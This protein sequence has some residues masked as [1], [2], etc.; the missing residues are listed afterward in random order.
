MTA[1]A[2]CF[3]GFFRLGLG[4]L[5]VLF[6]SALPGRAQ[7]QQVS[8]S[9]AQGT[10]LFRR[11]LHDLD[12]R[13]LQTYGQLVNDESK[14]L[15]IVLGEPGYLHPRQ[16]ADFVKQGGAVLLATDRD[17]YNVLK[18]FGVEV[19]GRPV[20]VSADTR[21]AYKRSEECI[22]VQPHGRESHL[23]ENLSVEDGLSRVATN[24]PGYLVCTPGCQLELLATFPPGCRTMHARPAHRGPYSERQPGV[25]PDLLP[26]AV[27]GDWEQG[28]VLILCDHS[29]FINAMMW[30]PDID[31]LDFAYN[32]V[33]WLTDRGKRTQVLFLEEGQVQTSFEIP[34]KE[35]PLPPLKAIVE[36]VNKGLGELERDNAFNR[37]I[38]NAVKDASPPQDQWERAVILLSTLALAAFGLARLSQARHRPEKAAPLAVSG[39]GPTRPTPSLFEQ[40]HQSMV[41]EGNFWEAARALARQ[42][43]ESVLGA[44]F[45]ADRQPSVS[46]VLALLGVQGS[47]WGKWRLRR[48]FN[49]LWQLAYGVEPIRI[50]SRQLTRLGSEIELMK[51]ALAR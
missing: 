8:Q 14:K 43:F 13:P 45:Q 32:C 42:G 30:Q 7:G 21:F 10:H 28:R 1:R 35:P 17:C 27:G 11:I 22:F 31:N 41:Q 2:Y 20:T 34:L 5:A 48:R 38:D 47:W 25:P 50:S 9:F 26:F 39:L 24:R 3:S 33:T 36:M 51:A 46:A 37:A 29:V 16:I 4:A 6:L 40:R 44:Q 19:V 18:P 23:F 15:L 12:L 49:R